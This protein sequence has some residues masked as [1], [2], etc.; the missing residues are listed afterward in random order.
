MTE[1]QKQAIALINELRY[2]KKVITIEEYFLLLEFIVGS[3]EPQI[4]Y[5]P[6]T[7][8]EPQP[9]D[10]VYG[11]FGKVTCD[12]SKVGTTLTGREEQQ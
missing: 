4:S 8:T 9:F 10:P 3:N 2:D 12:Q 11:K 5:I 1:R 6:F 7:Q